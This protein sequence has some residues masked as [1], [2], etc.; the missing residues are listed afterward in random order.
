[1]TAVVPEKR[2]RVAYLA[3]TSYCGSTL[4]AM[5]MDCHPQI[6][7]IGETNLNRSLRKKEDLQYRCS[8][9]DI[10]QD[11]TFWQQ[12]DQA[13]KDRGIAFNFR[14]WNN[15]YGHDN[16]MLDR[17]LFAYSN[18]PVR[19]AVQQMAMTILPGHRSSMQK[20]HKINIEFIESI[21]NIAK[22]D[23]F[24]DISKGPTRLYHLLH[25]PQIDV[26]VIRLVRDVRAFVNSCK[27]KNRSIEGGIKHWQNFHTVLEGLLSK[28]PE[29]KVFT[30]RYEDLCENPKLWLQKLY[31]FLDIDVIEP[32]E[33]IITKEHH[34][35]G[36]SRTRLKEKLT[37]QLNETWR[38]TLTEEELELS[39]RI[40]GA[41]N[42]RFGYA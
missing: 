5:V 4:M 18:N 38:E 11:C 8:C 23:V 40:A 3:G 34:I 25:V 31:E 9:G 19:R 39:M 29:E 21:L 17:I 32:P 1:M 14:T 20:L 33:F 27:R 2:N 41:T 35:I 22:A 6:A 16:A 24:F 13:L 37:I 30:L 7:T 10:L 26:K 42:Q 28:I 36:N 12:V 15:Y